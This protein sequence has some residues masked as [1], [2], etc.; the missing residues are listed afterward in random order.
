[1]ID[2]HC[3]YLPVKYSLKNKFKKADFTT[4]FIDSVIKGFEYNETNK[5]RQ[6]DF[7]IPTNLSE[8][9]KPRNSI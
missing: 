6:D 4:K 5:D 8:E 9:P 1:M 3:K 2:L 7:I